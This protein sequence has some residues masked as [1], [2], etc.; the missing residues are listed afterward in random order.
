M[1]VRAVDAVLSPRNAFII[2][3]K[4]GIRKQ[5]EFLRGEVQKYVGHESPIF[6]RPYTGSHFDASPISCSS[7]P[8]SRDSPAPAG[9]SRFPR[10]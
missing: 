9:E 1:R 8:F 10:G 6:H 3:N 2:A 4:V 5:I 7:R